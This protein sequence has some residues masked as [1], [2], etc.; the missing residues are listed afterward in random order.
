MGLY[1]N[2]LKKYDVCFKTSKALEMV[3]L[4]GILCGY[5]NVS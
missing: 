2:H 1:V 3:N 5:S 4:G